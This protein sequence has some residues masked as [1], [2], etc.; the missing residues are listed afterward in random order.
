MTNWQYDIKPVHRVESEPL[1]YNILSEWSA[2]PPT[3]REYGRIKHDNVRVWLCEVF[4]GVNEKNDRI[5]ELERKIEA[6]HLELDACW[7]A[8]ATAHGKTQAV[9]MVVKAEQELARMAQETALGG[10]A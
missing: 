3:P 4:H 2:R 10:D 6:Q 8:L 9:G 1:W 7:S 5:K